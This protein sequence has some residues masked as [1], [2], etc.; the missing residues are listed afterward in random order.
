VL[1]KYPGIPESI[2]EIKKAKKFI[3]SLLNFIK[4]LNKTDYNSK[5]WYR[6]IDNQQETDQIRIIIQQINVINGIV[7]T[8]FPNSSQTNN[9]HIFFDIDTTKYTQIPSHV[10]IDI[11]YNQMDFIR[12]TQTFVNTAI[13]SLN[14]E[15]FTNTETIGNATGFFINPDGSSG[16]LIASTSNYGLPGFLYYIYIKL[17]NNGTY[18]HQNG[19]WEIQ[20]PSVKSWIELNGEILGVLFTYTPDKLFIPDIE[21]NVLIRGGFPFPRVNFTHKQ[22][23]DFT[24]QYFLYNKS[25]NDKAFF[26]KNESKQTFTMDDQGLRHKDLYLIASQKYEEACKWKPISTQEIIYDGL[27]IFFY[28]QSDYF[29]P[30][31]AFNRDPCEDW[32]YAT[33]GSIYAAYEYFF[34]KGIR[35]AHPI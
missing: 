16:N 30:I 8:I 20:L 3:S 32:K 12:S 2:L 27:N 15:F 29:T 26:L 31:I 9:G 34:N 21:T 23:V 19:M 28:D 13:G 7:T 1:Q 6:Y 5:T 25:C 11:L 35:S 10:K 17:E 33:D 22:I 24:E 14:I 18:I 4:I